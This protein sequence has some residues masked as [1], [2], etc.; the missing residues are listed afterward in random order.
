MKNKLLFR[1]K[2][3]H[4]K[5]VRNRPKYL[6]PALKVMSQYFVVFFGW[7]NKILRNRPKYLSPALKVTSQYFLVL[8]L[9][10]GPYEL[11]AFL[12]FPWWSLLTPGF[13]S[14]WPLDKSLWG[15]LWIEYFFF[16]FL[17]EILYI[18]LKWIE[19]Y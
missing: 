1:K 10:V 17:K 3:L 18:R 9:L 15:H 2:I 7:M 6:S 5:I 14:S 13:A 8:F 12:S 11:R 4:N 16:F 19:I